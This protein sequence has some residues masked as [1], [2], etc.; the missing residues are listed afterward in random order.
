MFQYWT[1]W[2]NIPG[3][4]LK[5]KDQLQP[6]NVFAIGLN[7]FLRFKQSHYFKD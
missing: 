7:A 1:D 6:K 3:T 2:I 5:I 4:G